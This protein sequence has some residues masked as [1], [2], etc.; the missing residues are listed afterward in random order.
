MTAYLTTAIA[1]LT[2]THSMGPGTTVQG[3]HRLDRVAVRC[4]YTTPATNVG[5]EAEHEG[6]GE[7]TWS[8][9]ATVRRTRHGLRVYTEGLVY[10]SAGIMVRR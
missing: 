2:L 4:A 8:S 5:I 9:K 1:T 7:W 6:E 3:C 10:T